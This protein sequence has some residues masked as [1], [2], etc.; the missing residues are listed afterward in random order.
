MAVVIIGVA[1][2]LDLLKM[3]WKEQYVSE[4]LNRKVIP[5]VPQGIYRGLRL[6]YDGTQ[7]GTDRKV[8]VTSG[9][10][11]THEAVY[12]NTTGHALTYID[13]DGTSIIFDLSDAAL[14]GVDVVV[15]LFVD[16]QIGVD[17]VAEWRAYPIADYD[18]LPAAE[19]NELVILGTVKNLAASTNIV[20]ADIYVERR[21]VA[22]ENNPAGGRQWEPLLKSPGFEIGEVGTKRFDIVHWEAAT[23]GG[24]GT[25]DLSG[26][27][28]TGETGLRVVCTS[29]ATFVSELQHDVGLHVDPTQMIRYRVFKK[30]QTA[31]AGGTVALR[32]TFEDKTFNS[33]NNHDVVI[34]ANVTNAGFVEV[35]GMFTTAEVAIATG[36]VL[37]RVS[38]V[39]DGVDATTTVDFDGV[40]AWVEQYDATDPV[41]L[42]DRAGGVSYLNTLYL[43]DR[44]AIFGAA[45]SGAILEYDSSTNSVEITNPSNVGQD[46]ALGTANE[47]AGL[48]VRRDVTIGTST[49]GTLA[50]ADKARVIAPASVFAGVEY[51]LMW[52]SVPSGS[53]GYRQYV[54][55][56]GA[57]VETVNASWDNTNNLWTHDQTGSDAMKTT[58][59]ITGMLIQRRTTTAGT[60]NDSQWDVSEVSALG[61]NTI[62]I[63]HDGSGDA[64]NIEVAGADTTAQAL[65]VTETSKARTSELVH[66]TGSSTAGGTILEVTKADGTGA[67]VF[68][69]NNE[70]VG[71][72]ECLRIDNGST[73]TAATPIEI[74]HSG[75]AP[76]MDI[77]C[78]NTSLA[79]HGVDLDY[80]GSAD[81]INVDVGGTSTGAQGL[82]VNDSTAVVR[83]LPMVE[84]TKINAANFGPILRTAGIGGSAFFVY[85]S[86]AHEVLID[87]GPSSAFIINAPDAAA[88]ANADALLTLA[89]NTSD[90][91]DYE[92]IEC[93]S[94]GSDINSRHEAN[95]DWHTDTGLYTTGA[96]DYAECMDT[97]TAASNY[98]EGDLMVISSAGKVDKSVTANST[99]VIGVYSTNPSV[100]G[101]NPIS[102][103]LMD[104]G[105]LETNPWEWVQ[106]SIR[107]GRK[108]T[109]VD[110]DGDR[111]SVYAPGV[112]C[113][114]DVPYNNKG[115]K[116]I[117]S[118]YDGGTDKTSVR[119]NQAYPN[120]PAMTELYYTVPAKE[121]IPV[122]MLGLVP[123]K[124]ITENGTINPGD[125]LVSSSTA[126]HA[127]KA[128]SPAVGTVIGRAYE[129][130][131]DTGSQNDMAL[132]DCMVSI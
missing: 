108:W 48:R 54:S 21:T 14:D 36:T 131:T 105:T 29:G 37:R 51:T 39:I 117:T 83:A 120:F 41:N 94:S 73:S 86:G 104:Q 60:W 4:G 128:V 92:N 74:N 43:M 53:Q 125:L 103:L 70:T 68:L 38:L 9:G 8:A 122:G 121:C 126:G 101:N 91:V 42:S 132:I 113:R 114:M 35:E 99:A 62:D 32:F 79:A 52:E 18:A 111:T 98:E 118:T 58:K 112:R 24:T 31:T 30:V 56:T 75:L 102:D 45:A 100:L 95:G 27:I 107:N 22:W 85:A 25:W 81:A 7:G 40:Q 89:S 96:G 106:E 124:C 19:K 88:L 49:I 77:N 6:A 26:D 46:G 123:M 72:G 97:E 55:S 5:G 76:A 33:S 34:P 50:N 1:V 71:A 130:L 65:V 11:A 110:I 57:I 67:L 84:F 2:D 87:G 116:V 61:A 23:T 16:Y 63:D 80:D 59:S 47:E 13:S 3:K 93:I 119:F 129:T 17:T 109:H 90:A 127:M 115:L 20:A 44:A 28:R 69:D 15:A 10:D 12:Q 66:I 78:T 64:I 82:A